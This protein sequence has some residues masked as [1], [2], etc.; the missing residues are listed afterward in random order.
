MGISGWGW[1]YEEP[2]DSYG[3]VLFTSEESG[4]ITEIDIGVRSAPVSLQL[5]VYDSFS[6]NVLGNLILSK[7]VYIESS[8]WHSEDID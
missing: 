4:F 6:E 2:E 7:D 1:G 8:G 3:G 5:L